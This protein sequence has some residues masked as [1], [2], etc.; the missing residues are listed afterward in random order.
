MPKSVPKSMTETRH[1]T[2]FRHRLDS[3]PPCL[4]DV[5]WYAFCISGRDSAEIT[6]SAPTATTHAYHPTWPGAHRG[7]PSPYCGRAPF[8]NIWELRYG[9]LV[10]FSHA[11]A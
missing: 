5:R 11:Q 6:P 2:D 7:A 8:P 9:V 10:E 1:L 3:Y 4:T